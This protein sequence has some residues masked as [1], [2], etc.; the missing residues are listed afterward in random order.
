MT[1]LIEDTSTAAV[2]VAHPS[3]AAASSVRV[4]LNVVAA[5]LHR[6]GTENVVQ[7]VTFGVLVRPFTDGGE[8]VALN[9]CSFI[10][11]CRMVEGPEDVVEHL[12]NRHTRVFPRIQYTSNHVLVVFPQTTWGWTLNLRNSIL[13]DGGGHASGTRVEDVCEMIL[14]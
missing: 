6:I 10:S 7:F 12:V 11:D 3:A 8:H 9:L 13:Q 1:R 4:R 14:G 2:I 5:S